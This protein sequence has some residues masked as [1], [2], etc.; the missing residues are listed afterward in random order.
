MPR[1]SSLHIEPATPADARAIARIHVDAWRAAYPGIVPD[2][3]LAALSVDEREAQWREALSSGAAQMLVARSDGE[4]VGWVSFGACRDADAPASQGEIWA[5]Y[6]APAHIGKGIG[7]ALWLQARTQLR[8]QGFR[9]CSLWV[10]PEN[11]KAIRFYESVGFVADGLP[12]QRFE[13]GGKVLHEA[14]YRCRLD[15]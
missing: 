8:Q 15:D 13:L 3:Y 12:P 9:S 14:R 7:R 4:A 11:A 5:I 6:L 2:A 1:P 10:F